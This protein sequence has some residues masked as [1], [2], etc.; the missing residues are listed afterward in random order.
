[1]KALLQQLEIIVCQLAQREIM[2]RF[3][4][5]GFRLKTDGSLVTEADIAMQKAVVDELQKHWP[6]YELLGE[7]MSPQQQQ[8]LLDSNSSGL[9]VLDPLDGTSNFASGIPIFSVSL[10]L[11]QQG[12]VKL[13]LIYDPVRNEC[14]SAIRGQGAWLNQQSIKMEQASIPLKQCIAQVDLKRLP[15]TLASR[16]AAEHPFA[17][18]RNFGSGALDWCWLAV[19]RSQLYVHGGQKFWDYAAGQLILKE[20]GGHAISFDGQDVFKL[21]LQA[22]SIVAAHSEALLNDFFDQYLIPDP[23]DK[24]H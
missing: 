1:M 9:W 23:D 2:P 14:F 4:Q 24:N 7:E 19:G 11:I 17:S 3:N 20:A 18:Q 5:V 21:S 8:A 15:K 16:L 13:G 12:E 6:E 10:A 22:R